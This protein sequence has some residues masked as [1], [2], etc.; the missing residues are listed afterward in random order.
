MQF[1]NFCK[2]C[3]FK[4]C[5]YA[6]SRNMKFNISNL[7]TMKTFFSSITILRSVKSL[8]LKIQFVFNLRMLL[9]KHNNPQ[10]YARIMNLMDHS[11]VN[12]YCILKKFNILSIQERQF[13][14]PFLCN[15]M[16]VHI[17]SFLFSQF[18]TIDYSEQVSLWWITNCVEWKIWFLILC[19][20]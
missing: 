8:K 2:S 5:Q 20:R 19:R 16:K 15:S 10:V 14:G 1:V 18:G 4:E 13:E 17:M 11:Q 6:V 9:T 3:I 12:Y 7:E